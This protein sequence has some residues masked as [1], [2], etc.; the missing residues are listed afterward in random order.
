MILV[1]LTAPTVIAEWE[2]DNWLKNIIGPERLGLGDE[3]GCHG[4]E[5]I[6]VRE[7]SWVIQDCRDY[8][9]RF[10]DASRWGSQP[11]S[12][13]HPNGPVS[14]DTAQELSNSGFAIIGDRIEGEAYGL[15]LIHI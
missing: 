13:G 10:T 6:D 14:E 3:F 1:P 15:S 12:F 5:G 9:N 2:D 8:L 4:F 7:E 11:V